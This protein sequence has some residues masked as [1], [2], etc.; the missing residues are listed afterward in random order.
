MPGDD[1]LSH[2]EAPHYH[3]RRRVSLL[4]S[5]RDQVGHHRYGRQA[6]LGIS[7]FCLFV[8]ADERS[9]KGIWFNSRKVN[10]FKQVPPYKY[11]WCCMVKPLEQLVMV[12][13]MYYYTSTPILSTSWSIRAL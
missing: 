9:A 13:Y 1:L 7:K 5:V 11:F 12:S 6:E 2:G 8:L 4:S 3:W 10:A